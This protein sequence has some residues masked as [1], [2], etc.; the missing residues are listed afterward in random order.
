MIRFIT[1]F[2]CVC[3]VYNSSYGGDTA[4]PDQALV[5]QQTVTYPATC[6]PKTYAIPQPQMVT[7][8]R[9]QMRPQTQTIE[10]EQQRVTYEP[11]ITTEKVQQQVTTY[12]PEII[13]EEVQVQTVLP[14][15]WQRYNYGYSGFDMQFGLR[16]RL[17][18]VMTPLQ[19]AILNAQRAIGIME[20]DSS[21]R[22]GQLR[23]AKRALARLILRIRE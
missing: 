6:S 16:S 1:A 5:P 22:P 15:L 13:T 20:E 21:T 7:Q 23:R 14:Y 12:I 10:T 19:I 2:F 4:P 11:K 8:Q 9:I 18:E 17:A 3:I